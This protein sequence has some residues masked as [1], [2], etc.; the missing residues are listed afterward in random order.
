MGKELVVR[1]GTRKVG[2]KKKFKKSR[3]TIPK[4]HNQKSAAATKPLTRF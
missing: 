3:P 1:A 4:N 2:G